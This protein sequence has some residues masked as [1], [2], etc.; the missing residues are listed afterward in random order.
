MSVSLDTKCEL[1]TLITKRQVVIE[2]DTYAKLTGAYFEAKGTN[3]ASKIAKARSALLTGYFRD[4]VKPGVKMVADTKLMDTVSCPARD[5]FSGEFT[6]YPKADHLKVTANVVD[7]NFGMSAK[8]E[9]PWDSSCVEVFI[10]PAGVDDT[11]NRFFIIPDGINGQVSVRNEKNDKIEAVNGTWKRTAKGYA[12]EV[13]IPWT[14]VAGYEKGW[15]LLPVEAVVNSH[16]GS[17]RSKQVMVSMNRTGYP[18]AKSRTYA[19]LRAK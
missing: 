3:D 1:G 10:S 8:Q 15:S 2:D 13:K 17:D 19:V 11:V 12:V 7:A 9:N 4:M 5:K 6:W 18:W 16:V 14:S